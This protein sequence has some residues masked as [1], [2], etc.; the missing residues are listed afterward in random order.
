M[1]TGNV[2]GAT[3]GVGAG[4]RFG[5]GG[6]LKFGGVSNNKNQ[7]FRSEQKTTSKSSDSLS[8]RW[9]VNRILVGQA[10]PPRPRDRV[11]WSIKPPGYSTRRLNQNRTPDDEPLPVVRV[12]P[13]D[14]SSCFIFAWL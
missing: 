14:S 2:T 11:S 9:T 4:L 13:V 10:A 5:Q 8:L 7:R 1:S 3:D 12:V 6:A